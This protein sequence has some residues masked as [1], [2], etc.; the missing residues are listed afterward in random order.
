METTLVSYSGKL[1]KLLLVAIV[2]FPLLVITTAFQTQPTFSISGI[3]NV[4]DEGVLFIYLVDAETFKKPMT[5]LQKVT[6]KI[7]LNKKQPGKIPFTFKGVPKGTYGIRCFIDMD[8][9]N[10]LNHG[11]FGPSEPWGMSSKERPKGIPSFSDI[12]FKV[13]KSIENII[14]QVK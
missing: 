10:K 11:F 9:N 14:I 7:V 4:N 12:S 3:C 6:Q 8:G 5:G 2:M 13:D 1:K